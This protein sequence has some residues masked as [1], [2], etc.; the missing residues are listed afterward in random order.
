MTTAHYKIHAY[1][2]T[3]Q[4]NKPTCNAFRSE[5]AGSNTITQTSTARRCANTDDIRKESWMLT[6]VNHPDRIALI[7]H[8]SLS[9]FWNTIT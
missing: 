2:S 1:F 9:G 3:R 5:A 8:T 6:V 4:S 7:R